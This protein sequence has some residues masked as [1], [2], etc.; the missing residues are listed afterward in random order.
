MSQFVEKVQSEVTEVKDMEQKGEIRIEKSG[1]V[2]FVDKTP[3][4]LQQDD[5]EMTKSSEVKQS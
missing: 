2:T 1:F 5:T 3:K 4:K